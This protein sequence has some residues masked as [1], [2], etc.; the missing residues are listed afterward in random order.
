MLYLTPCI[1]KLWNNV[2][3]LDSDLP[4][5]APHALVYSQWHHFIF[6]DMNAYPPYFI[7]E[8]VL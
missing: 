4:P 1:L 8:H 5:L 6:W 7:H 3:P 2:E